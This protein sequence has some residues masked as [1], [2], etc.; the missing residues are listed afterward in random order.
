VTDHK[1][2][3][4]DGKIKNPLSELTPKSRTFVCLFENRSCKKD[5][6]LIPHVMNKINKNKLIVQFVNLR[7]IYVLNTIIIN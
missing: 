4:H 7:H 5:P 3:F 1:R 2:F 6:G